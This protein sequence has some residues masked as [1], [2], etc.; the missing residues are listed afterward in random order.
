MS[1]LR[2][3]GFGL[4]RSKK[5]PD[6]V[7]KA[8]AHTTTSET[9]ESRALQSGEAKVETSLLRIVESAGQ[10]SSK[11]P[12]PNSFHPCRR[13][14]PSHQA[15]QPSIDY[16]SGHVCTSQGLRAQIRDNPCRPVAAQLDQSF[17][18]SFGS[19]RRAQIVP[20]S[21][22]R[23]S[24]RSRSVI[25]NT[26][27]SFALP[28]CRLPHRVAHLNGNASSQSKLRL[29]GP[30]R[31]SLTAPLASSLALL[32]L[33][34]KGD[35]C[36]RSMILVDLAM[37][38]LFYPPRSYSRDF[39]ATSSHSPRTSSKH[40]ASVAL[41]CPLPRSQLRSCLCVLLLVTATLWHT[42]HRH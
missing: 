17:R 35:L 39:G 21:V 5:R 9:R 8:K 26:G 38:S 7:Q 23:R 14:K 3:E 4:A 41:L 36:S 29:L 2:V 32:R 42:S 13:C 19:T 20:R 34:H 12:D 37:L 11:E 18:R 25:T 31:A 28:G 30:Y 33:V 27:L 24:R 1:L 10:G 15:Q 16:A 40:H 6:L 22:S